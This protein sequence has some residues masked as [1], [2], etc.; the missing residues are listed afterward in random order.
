M[1][2]QHTHIGEERIPGGCHWSGIV[3]R[4]TTLRLTVSRSNLP[5]VGR[6][7]VMAILDE[8]DEKA[9]IQ[10]LTE[11]KNALAKQYQ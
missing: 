2:Q 5:F 4:G 10:I 8:L 6:L 11:P 1:E 9:L 3:R 7:P